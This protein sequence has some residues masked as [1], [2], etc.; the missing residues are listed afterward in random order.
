MRRVQTLLVR[1]RVHAR[2]GGRGRAWH[3][4]TSTS[5]RQQ[6]RR[7]RSMASASTRR[8]ALT[9]RRAW[10]VMHT[11]QVC[12]RATTLTSAQW[13][14]RVRAR[15]RV[16]TRWAAS[17]ARA[18]RGS[19]GAGL[20]ASSAGRGLTAR[21]GTRGCARCVRQASSTRT[22]ARRAQAT[23]NRARRTGSHLATLVCVCLL[24]F[25]PLG[26]IMASLQQL[27]QT[28]FVTLVLLVLRILMFQIQA[29]VCQ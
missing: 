20:C 21:R 4:P 27:L 5:V 2:R 1:L 26:I 11:T 7:A 29:I 14:G 17:R 16:P 12:K 23:V 28:K 6:R 9:V 24:R 22:M 15:R 8:A 19:P 3:A 13:T 18:G 25:A 10:R